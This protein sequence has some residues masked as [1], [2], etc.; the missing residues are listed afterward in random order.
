MDILYDF[1]KVKD[2]LFVK[3]KIGQDVITNC[4]LV[5]FTTNTEKY[6]IFFI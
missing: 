2:C 1:Q 5:F 4:V 3:S 6:C